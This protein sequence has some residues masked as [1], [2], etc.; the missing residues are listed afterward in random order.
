MS[1][2]QNDYIVKRLGR[3][4]YKPEQLLDYIKEQNCL[5]LCHQPLQE[6][7]FYPHSSGVVVEGFP[8]KVWVYA[9]CWTS[10]CLYQNALWKLCA[11]DLASKIEQE[12]HGVNGE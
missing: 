7:S 12:I 10:G 2:Y 9:T 1:D 3:G 5:G 8:D 11:I 6:I 4:P